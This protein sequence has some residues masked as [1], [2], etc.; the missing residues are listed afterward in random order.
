[1]TDR[2][3]IAGGAVAAALLLAVTGCVTENAEP[4][5]EAEVDFPE[6]QF[7]SRPDLVAPE[8]GFSGEDPPAVQGA[9]DKA[10][11]FIA[12]KDG[13]AP[14]RGP[15]I[16][17]QSGEPVW[18]NPVGSRYTYD[19]RV[20]QYE[21]E[22]VLT[23]W[24]GKHTSSGFG[25]GE[26]VLVDESYREIGS[27]TTPGVHADFHHMDIT[28]RGTA[29]MTAFPIVRRDLSD[30]GGPEN[31][32]VANCVV[33]EVDIETGKVL[34]RWNMIED[35]PLEETR[36]DSESNPDEPGTK[37]RPLDPYHVNSVAEDG[38][39]GLL[40][41]ARNTSAIYRIDKSSGE[42]DWTLG[43][44][45]SDFEMKGDS[46]FYYQHDAQ[47]REDGTISLFDN[48]G[49]PAMSDESRGLILDVDEKTDT[50]RVV[51]QYL[52][53]DGRLSSSQGNMQVRPNGNVV[54]GWGSQ[55]FYSE[56]TA[57]G[58]LLTDASVDGQSYRAFRFPWHASPI[59]PPKF[60]FENDAAY[61]SWNGATEVDAWRFLAGNDE[62]TAKEVDTVP[63]DG[64]ETSLE[65]PDRPYIAAQAL[66]AQGNVLA[67]AE[68]GSWPY[69]M[70]GGT[71]PSEPTDESDQK[72]DDQDGQGDPAKPEQQ[73]DDQPEKQ[74]DSGG[75]PGQG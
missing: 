56:Y 66:D 40:V 20:Q 48:Q 39:D 28:S 62:A 51:Q 13:D 58:R 7:V 31:G 65:M 67:T 53:P 46:E 41:S 5:T 35:V 68:P 16:M 63:R 64:F 12:P 55:E 24:Q 32:Y 11:T 29:L 37:A 33:Q 10:L 49:D 22:P 74:G 38:K 45:G 8:I 23:W 42:L 9:P 34:F 6:P 59:E 19:F 50:A 44:N 26:Y 57:D 47:R 4:A 60:T 73:Q 2:R 14:M 71:Q 61:V 30:M 1:M 54:I 3:L 72:S 75:T 69:D 36:E 70:T 21:G 43:G 52:P 17:D 27:V 25:H 18:I 15:V